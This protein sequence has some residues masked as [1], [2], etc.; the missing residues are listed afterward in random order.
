MRLLHYIKGK[1]KGKEAH[2]IELD[3]MSDPFLADALEGFDS[4]PGNHPDTIRKLRNEING[5][6]Q[7]R[8]RNIILWSSMAASILLLITAGWY[9]INNHQP[10]L[11]VSSSELNVPEAPFPETS[12]PKETRI[13]NE[14]E[15][16]HKDIRYI[17][18][19]EET[20]ES[21]RE[22]ETAP[23]P[24]PAPV[25]SIET[26]SD[27]IVI[28]EAEIGLD[29]VLDEV[30]V[31]GYG[32]RI[33]RIQQSNQ[34]AAKASEMVIDTKQKQQ[35]PIAER[36]EALE[37]D[38]MVKESGVLPEPV[39]GWKNY[40]KYLRKSLIRPAEQDSCSKVKGTVEVRFYVDH[41]GRP[42]D[43]QVITGLC[44]T[45][46][47]EAVRLINE[48]GDWTSGNLPVLIKIRF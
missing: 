14:A 17:G 15:S 24:P 25:I 19:E 2:R 5:T 20:E 6:S 35:E 41:K 46:D 3:A 44:K 48:G 1:R 34:R 11:V 45:A 22:K 39:A 18:V 7:V 10:Q 43:I 21:A 16:N 37:A 23:S 42:K 36:T 30:V 38:K 26:V 40:R 47:K 13:V 12:A 28:E 32:D 4:V 31:T 8:T 9:F 27:D 29:P 33:S